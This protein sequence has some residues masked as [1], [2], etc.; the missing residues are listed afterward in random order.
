MPWNSQFYCTGLFSCAG[1]PVDFTESALPCPAC[2]CPAQQVVSEPG[3]TAGTA[4]KVHD[5]AW[6]ELACRFT[7]VLPGRYCAAW[8]LRL[9][10]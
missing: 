1:W 2:H 9:Q 4:V 7:G 8:R 10:V 6:L 3:S 5:V